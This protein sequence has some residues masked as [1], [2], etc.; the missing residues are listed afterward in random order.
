MLNQLL[1]ALVANILTEQSQ[2]SRIFSN[3]LSYVV[4]NTHLALLPPVIL[5]GS[6]G[7]WLIHATVVRQTFSFIWVLDSPKCSGNKMGFNEYLILQTNRAMS[8]LRC[9]YI[10]GIP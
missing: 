1:F 10:E 9:F 7:L 6:E 5:N 3:I 4:S 2:N 8:I